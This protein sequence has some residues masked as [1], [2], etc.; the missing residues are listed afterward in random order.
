MLLKYKY[1]NKHKVVRLNIFQIINDKKLCLK[2]FKKIK[3]GKNQKKL[4]PI[5][6]YINT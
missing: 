4:V 1:I 3:L 6:T 5:L 2:H